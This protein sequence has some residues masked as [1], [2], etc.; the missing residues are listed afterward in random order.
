MQQP[1]GKK[2]CDGEAGII[3][4]SRGPRQPTAHQQVHPTVVQCTNGTCRNATILTG[5]QV[6]LSPNHATNTN[7]LPKVSGF[8]ESC[9][10]WAGEGAPGAVDVVSAVWSLPYSPHVS[11]GAITKFNSHLYCPTPPYVPGS[12]L[13][14]L[15]T[16]ERQR[17]KSK[18]KDGRST[19]KTSGDGSY[20]CSL[21]QAPR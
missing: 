20:G 8:A 6:S 18:E 4:S 1:A 3:D 10:W 21:E 12:I 11:L 14:N 2:S 16:A 5:P 13:R 7:P 17:K 9:P 15:S 19:G